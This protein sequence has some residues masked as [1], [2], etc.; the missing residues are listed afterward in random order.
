MAWIRSEG[1]ISQCQCLQMKSY[2]LRAATDA[3]TELLRKHIAALALALDRG[4]GKASGHC[5]KLKSLQSGLRAKIE[6][7]EIMLLPFSA[8]LPFQILGH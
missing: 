1:S 4:E 7:T 2:A 6:L 3:K 8:S 5:S